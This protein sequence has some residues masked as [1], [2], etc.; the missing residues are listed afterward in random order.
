MLAVSV[1]VGSRD[2]PCRVDGHGDL[3]IIGEPEGGSGPRR[4][5]RGDGAI[6]RAQEAVEYAEE[7]SAWNEVVSGDFPRRVDGTGEGA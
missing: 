2:H 4:V 5:K 1:R 3:V 6:G 7:S